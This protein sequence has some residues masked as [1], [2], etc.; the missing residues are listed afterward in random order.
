MSDTMH[1]FTACSHDSQSQKFY[2]YY[3]EYV[4]LISSKCQN[5]AFSMFQRFLMSM[6]TL[7]FSSKLKFSK[8]Y[9]TFFCG[10]SLNENLLSLLFQRVSS[11]TGN[12]LSSFIPSPKMAANKSSRNGDVTSSSSC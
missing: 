10:Q 6:G 2:Y 4:L 5:G 9:K 7:F 11:I 12:T 8:K 1:Y 3:W